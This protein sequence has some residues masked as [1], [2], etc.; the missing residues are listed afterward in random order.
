MATQDLSVM[1]GAMAILKTK[2]GA[3]LG[4]VKSLSWT[5]NMRTE[6]VKGLG[7]FSPLKIETMSW[8]GSGRCSFVMVNLAETGMQGSLNRDVATVAQFVNT[9]ILSRESFDLFVYKKVPKSFIEKKV[10]SEIEE[11]PFA[12]IKGIVIESDAVDLNV[13]SFAMRNQS[14]KFTEPV[15]YTK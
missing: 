5:E 9:L 2:E 3:T 7:D 10:V 12:I 13:D 15:L 1:K 14:F 6:E 11:I 4:I 8:S